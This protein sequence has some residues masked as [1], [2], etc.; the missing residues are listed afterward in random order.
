MVIVASAM[1]RILALLIAVTLALTLA[2]TLTHSP[3]L[4]WIGVATFVAAFLAY[5]AWRREVRRGRVFDQ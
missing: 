1:R 2:A 5:V 4:G 3:A